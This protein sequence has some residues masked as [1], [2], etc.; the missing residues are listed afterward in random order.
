MAMSRT[1]VEFVARLMCVS[2]E[3][4]IGTAFNSFSSLNSFA[5]FILIVALF[6]LRYFAFRSPAPIVGTSCCSSSIICSVG[7]PDPAGMYAE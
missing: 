5:P 4:P 3:G 6:Q 1:S 7:R 2:S